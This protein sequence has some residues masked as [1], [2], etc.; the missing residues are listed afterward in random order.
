MSECLSTCSVLFMFS[1][2]TN[3]LT[4]YKQESFFCALCSSCCPSLKYLSLLSFALPLLLVI[5]GEDR[6][7]AFHAFIDFVHLD[8]DNNQYKEMYINQFNFN[9]LSHPHSLFAIALG[10]FSFP[11]LREDRTYNTSSWRR[12]KEGTILRY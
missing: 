10:P 2:F 6:L 1:P 12:P 11:A 7:Y 3:K 5:L 4:L 9:F 8:L